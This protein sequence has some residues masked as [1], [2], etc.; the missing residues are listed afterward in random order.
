LRFCPDAD[1]P[2]DQVQVRPLPLV[3]C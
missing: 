2:V 1:S 3:A